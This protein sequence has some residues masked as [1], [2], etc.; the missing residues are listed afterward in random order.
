MEFSNI[1]VTLPFTSE[2]KA[3]LQEASPQ[4]VFVFK[5]GLELSKEDFAG[6]DA[7]IG[8]APPVLLADAPGLK[9]VQ[10]GSVGAETFTD[11]LPSSVYLT[12]ARGA[13]GATVAGHAFAVTWMLLKKLHLYRDNQNKGIW[14]DE[15]MVGEINENTTALIIGTGDIGRRY[16]AMIKPFGARIL[17]VKRTRGGTIPEI[18]ELYCTDELPSLLPRADIVFLCLPGGK[19]TTGLIGE[20]EFGVMKEGAV[21][22][23]VGRGGAIDTAALQNALLGGRL[24]AAG[25]DVTD[26]EPLPAGHP[27]WGIK[28]AFITPHVSGGFHLAQTL[29]NIEKIAIRNLLLLKDGKEPENIVDREL[30]YVTVK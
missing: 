25:L 29:G 10:L 14:S 2:Q 6:A 13:Y 11:I 4:T 22:I 3:R 15:G 21:I 24:A 17:G 27:L 23:N 18:D 1:V 12:N 20:S 26:P 30:G 5:Q 19:S 16:A 9:W 28:N 8:G 7:L